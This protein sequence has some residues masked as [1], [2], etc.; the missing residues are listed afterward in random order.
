NYYFGDAETTPI[1]IFDNDQ[2]DSLA[3]I[4]PQD[5]EFQWAVSTESLSGTEAILV[6]EAVG[7]NLSKETVT[8]PIT[9]EAASAL[10]FT[11]LTPAQN[12][13]YNIGDRISFEVEMQGE[14]SL[15]DEFNA[16]ISGSN[17][18]FYSTTIAEN[19]ITFDLETADLYEAAY[20]LNFELITKDEEVVSQNFSFNLIEYIPTFEAL[21]ANGYELKS[22]IQTFDN[23]YLT[24]ASDPTAGTIVT[25][26]NEEGVELWNTEDIGSDPIPAGIGVAESICEDTEY[27]KG[28]VIA[29]WVDN[30]GDKDTW[31]RKINQTDGSL[32][33][34]KHY[35]YDWCDDGATVIKKSVDDGYIIGGYTLNPYGTDS[36]IFSY[37]IGEDTYSVK[38]TWETG[39]DAR[40]L[41]IYSN[42]NEVWGHNVSY[43][44]RKMWHDITLH[45][46]NGFLWV[47]K[48][49][50]QMITDLVAKENGNYLVTGWNNCRLYYEDGTDK[51]DMFF[52]EYDIFGGYVSS[53]TWS[54]MFSCD[55]GYL[56]GEDDPY[57]GFL[58]VVIVGANHIGDYTE[59]EIG[60]SLVESQGG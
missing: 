60:Y 43:I 13:E 1:T 40:L 23:G 4:Q 18:A 47:K 35:G 8:I 7:N 25:K 36:L 55:Q 45:K 17:T 57:A 14:L 22:I 41:K 21:G 33:W 51:K 50:D 26:Y 59:D 12:Q 32:I 20:M 48:M 42:G 39:Y 5:A 2:L 15:F 56:A 58:N 34:N 44:G 52:A 54:R 49:G 46:N 24:V 3:A 10:I 9:L 30:A 29:G 27:D 19:I 6:V 31:V 16:Y 37:M 28:Y 38:T 53:L 11:I